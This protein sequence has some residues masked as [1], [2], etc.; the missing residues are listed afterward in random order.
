MLV[1]RADDVVAGRELLV[2]VEAPPREAD[3][4]RRVQLRVLGIDRD[5]ELDHLVGREPVEDDGGDLHV[6]RLAR[7]DQLVEGKETVLPVERAQH[8]LLRRD[9]QHPQDPMGARGRELEPPVGDQQ[10]GTRDR[11][12]VPGLGTLPVVLDQIRDLLADDGPLVRLRAGGD[13]PFEELPVDAGC[14]PLALGGRW[15]VVCAGPVR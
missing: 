3:Q 9:L 4:V 5:E 14:S 11:R 15:A 1:Q 13:P 6:L 10:D 8:A 7:H 2:R 12:Q